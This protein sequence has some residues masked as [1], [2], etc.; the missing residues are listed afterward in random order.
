MRHRDQIRRENTAAF[1]RS[2]AAGLV[3]TFENRSH[4]IFGISGPKRG[5]VL[6]KLRAQS[7]LYGHVG[8]LGH[9]QMIRRPF[10]TEWDTSQL[11]NN[12][13]TYLDSGLSF[14]EVASRVLKMIAATLLS[15]I[16]AT[17]NRR[18]NDA[19]PSSKARQP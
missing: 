5:P 10:P 12:R 9:I 13:R 7:E 19:L 3:R 16:M 8:K 15:R 4:E 17:I 2:S 14:D 11:P 18:P 1:S 6:G